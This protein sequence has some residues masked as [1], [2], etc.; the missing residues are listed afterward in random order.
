[1]MAWSVWEV[2]GNGCEE[3]GREGLTHVPACDEVREY[4]GAHDE[5][6]EGC[7]LCMGLN[8]YGVYTYV[9]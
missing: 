2:L 4:D 3:R 6:E 5:R 1:M 8:P 9:K 7:A